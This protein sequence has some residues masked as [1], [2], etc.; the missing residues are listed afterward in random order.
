MD[1]RAIAIVASRDVS[2]DGFAGVPTA[3]LD[4]LGR[5]VLQ[6]AVDRLRSFGIDDITVI[7]EYGSVPTIQGVRWVSALGQSAWRLANKAF[8]EIAQSGAESVLLTH[9]GPYAE[10][11]YED[12]VQFHLDQGSRVTAVIEPDSELT[13]TFV[14][15]PTRRNDAAYLFRHQLRTSRL[16]HSYYEFNGYFN[17]L[18]TAADLRRLAVDA[19][20]GNA[21]LEPD[22]IEVKPG[23]WAAPTAR[24][25]KRA[26]VLAPSYIGAHARVR[27]A[28]VVTRCSVLE[29]HAHVDCGTVVDNAT[30]LPNTS[31]G[32][33]L[34]V[35]HSVVGSRRL[36]HLGR[37]VEVEIADPK[38]VGTVSNAPLRLVGH[39][40]SLASFLP[41][42]VVRGI[43][44]RGRDGQPISVPEA[45][46]APSPALKSAT[47]E[48]FSPNLIIA[49][50]YGNE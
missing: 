12:L 37:N 19:F 9:V 31:I 20:C 6:R 27:A 49:R 42:Q 46:Q 10:I 23:V 11:D 15:N 24:I 25:H 14:L 7:S 34:D 26:R 35:A 45:V 2:P 48:S 28:A 17:P 4:L 33:G 8:A 44:K 43:V 36:F 47:D 38:L 50:R 30:L 29:H 5:S 16:P 21:E 1:V 22:G 32:A 3:F 13:G 18:S 41:A 39:L 40:A